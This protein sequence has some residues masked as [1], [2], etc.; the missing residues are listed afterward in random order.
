MSM[1]LD[2]VSGFNIKD[3]GFHLDSQEE[4]EKVGSTVGLLLPVS[5]VLRTTPVIAKLV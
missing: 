2:L 4:T 5:L 1:L 3:V